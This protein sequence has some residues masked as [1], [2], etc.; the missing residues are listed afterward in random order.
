M[1]TGQRDFECIRRTVESADVS[2]PLTAREILEL[3]EATGEDFDSPHRI[4]TIL[5]RHAERGAVEVI[6][7]KPYRYRVLDRED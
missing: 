4:A 2:E 7:S 6:E 1:Q 3:L 5:G